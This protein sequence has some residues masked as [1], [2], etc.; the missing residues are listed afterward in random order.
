MRYIIFILVILIPDLLFGQSFPFKC[1]FAK[2][3]FGEYESTEHLATSL[4]LSDVYA[5]D[6]DFDGISS[7]CA[8]YRSDCGTDT[9]NLQLV[10]ESETKGADF[11]EYKFTSPEGFVILF[12]YNLYGVPGIRELSIFH[13]GKTRFFYINRVINVN[14]SSKKK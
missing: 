14:I 2:M 8:I 11:V 6:I 3:Y 9:L 10:R 7:F 5:I 4:R 12:W 13:P 1:T